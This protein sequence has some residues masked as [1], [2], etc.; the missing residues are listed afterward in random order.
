MGVLHYRNQEREG[1]LYGF[2]GQFDDDFKLF[3]FVPALIDYEV[4]GAHKRATERMLDRLGETIEA[5]KTTERRRELKHQRKRL[6][7]ALMQDIFALYR[8]M[9]GM[10]FKLRIEKAWGAKSGI[11]AATGDCCA[12]KL[13][14]EANRLGYKV[15]GVAEI[16]VGSARQQSDQVHG[17]FATPC[18][19]KC[20]PHSVLCCVRTLSVLNNTLGANLPAC[21]QNVASSHLELSCRC[22]LRKDL[23]GYQNHT[24]D[25]RD[26]WSPRAYA[27]NA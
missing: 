4:M 27:N 15:L 13:L 1:F 3:G 5:T 23:P 11:P 21:P 22:S 12:P 10:G 19:A 25:Y 16:F 24:R 18:A 17:Q 20:Q 14:Q 7:Q 9:T 8:P 26:M 6:S 2:S